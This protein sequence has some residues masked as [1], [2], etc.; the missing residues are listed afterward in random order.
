MITFDF[1]FESNVYFEFWNGTYIILRLTEFQSKL[2]SRNFLFYD[3]FFIF[4]T[5]A[6]FS[7]FYQ[8]WSIFVVFFSDFFQIFSRFFWFFFIFCF[9]LI[10]LKNYR[11]TLI[12]PFFHISTPKNPLSPF[13]WLI[14]I[15]QVFFPIDYSIHF[16]SRHWPN[17]SGVYFHLV[18]RSIIKWVHIFGRFNVFI[19]TRVKMLF[20][21]R[22]FFSNSW[23]LLA[24][25]ETKINSRFVGAGSSRSM[26]CTVNQIIFIQLIRKRL[27]GNA[28]NHTFLYGTICISV[29]LSQQ[30]IKIRANMSNYCVQIF[31]HIFIFFCLVVVLFHIKFI[32]A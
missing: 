28:M 8:F 6:I 32:N 16:F 24:D 9:F 31:F 4:F 17:Q 12:F 3:T 14:E 29:V 13:D 27:T 26:M 11:F 10:L 15:F 5:F 18:N 21:S 7:N 30:W 2:F 22:C 1:Q 23:L 19:M 25:V 20:Q